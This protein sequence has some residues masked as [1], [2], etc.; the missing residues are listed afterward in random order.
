VLLLSA[1]A[2]T[3]LWAHNSRHP[4]ALPTRGM[5]SNPVELPLSQPRKEQGT[6][7]AKGQ[8]RERKHSLGRDKETATVLGKLLSK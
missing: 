2:H 7:M 1:G 8:R 5:H 3:A 4:K 6:G